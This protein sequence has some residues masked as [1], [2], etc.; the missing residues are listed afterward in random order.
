MMNAPKMIALMNEFSSRPDSSRPL[1]EKNFG[2]NG[3][4][5]D[6]FPVATVPHFLWAQWGAMGRNGKNRGV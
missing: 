5:G 1:K 4:N 3:K 2:R 6:F